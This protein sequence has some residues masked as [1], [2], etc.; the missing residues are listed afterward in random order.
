M[1]R[2]LELQRVGLAVDRAAGRVAELL[3]I[4][5][6]EVSLAVCSAFDPRRQ[7][8]A[9][10]LVRPRVLEVLVGGFEAAAGGLFDEPD[11]GVDEDVRDD[12]SDEAVGDAVGEGHHGDGQESG[13]RVAHVVPV[14]LGGG[15]HHHG[16]D[17]DERAAG[18]PGRDGGENW[19]EEDGDEEAEAGRDGCETCRA[20]FRDA[21]AGFDEGGNWGAAEERA[22]C[23]AE[24]VDEVG[25]G[26]AFEVLGLFVDGTGEAGHGVHGAGAV[27]D[28]NI[29]ESGCWLDMNSCWW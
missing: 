1:L 14:D 28:V 9:G 22:D 29:E 25:D 27:E 16:S 19:R 23:Y 6:P 13:D 12:A 20:A 8:S 4:L 3:V 26:G 10:K 15:F 5:S 21:G 24:G 7:N 2:L 11:G 17:D 18:G